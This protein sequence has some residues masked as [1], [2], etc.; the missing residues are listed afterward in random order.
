MKN[1]RKG[2]CNKQ[3]RNVAC[4]FAMVAVS[5]GLI[6]ALVS[7][8]SDSVSHEVEFLPFQESKGGNWGMIGVDGEVLFSEEF[9]TE[10]SVAVNGRFL[11]K[12]ASANWEIYTTDKK[13]QKVGGEY[14]HAGLF[15]CDVAPVV[16]AGQPIKFIDRDG[17]VRVTLDKIGGK[18]VSRCSNFTNGQALVEVDG[19]WGVVDTDGDVVIEPKYAKLSENSQGYYIA[20]DK[21]YESETD[22]ENLSYTI[23]NDKGKEVT[24]VK[25]SKIKDFKPVKTSNRTIGCIVQDAMIVETDKGGDRAHGLMTFDGEWKMPPSTKISRFIQN[26]GQYFIYHSGNGFGLI[27]MNGE[28]KIRAKYKLMCF[29]D[30]DILMVKKAGDDDVM[31]LSLDDEQVGKDE[32]IDIKPFYD[33]VHAFAQVGKHDYVLL[34]KKGEEQKLKVDIYELSEE[35]MLPDYFESDFVDV[36]DLIGKLHLEKEGF[37]GF[38]SAMTGPEAIN[39]ANEMYANISQDAKKYHDY[40]AIEGNIKLG[41]LLPQLSMSTAGLTEKRATGS[42]WLSYTTTQ[43]TSN[44]VLS[45]CLFFNVDANPQLSGKMKDLYSKL[46]DALKSKGKVERQGKNAAVIDTGNPYS[47]YIGWAGKLVF[48]Y[49][50]KYN[51]NTCIVD[52]YDNV[53]ETEQVFVQMPELFV[54][55][56][57]DGAEDEDWGELESPP[58]VDF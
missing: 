57:A 16:E 53:T 50:G 46:L 20:L 12:N 13:P 31:L 34:N 29:L 26:R 21:K 38:T 7:C 45:Y 9:T 58:T 48:L 35:Q 51:L 49:F 56:S 42:G 33:G 39:R 36:D 23:L 17:N 15:Y 5:L 6:Q 18:A 40:P 22:M 25:G 41:K 52:D 54:E 2:L 55:P 44:P 10:P 37:L 11:V 30:D 4:M 14:L 19:Y 3:K 47:Y 24:T 32:Y 8:S 28:E 43:W 27:D 1:P